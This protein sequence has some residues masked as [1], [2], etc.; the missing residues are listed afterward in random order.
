MLLKTAKATLAAGLIC[1]ISPAVFAAQVIQ[2]KNNKVMIDTQDEPLEVGQEFYLL[3]TDSKKVGL[4]QISVVKNGK[5]IGIVTKGKSGG[6]ETLEL[7]AGSKAS[8]KISEDVEDADSGNSSTKTYRYGSK[9][10]SL[11]LNLITNSMTAKESDGASPTPHIEDVSMTGSSFGLTGVLDSPVNSWFTFRG[12]VGYEPFKASGT[13]NY[14]GCDSATSTNCT[15]EMTYLSV[16]AY[17]RFDFYKSNALLAWGAIGGTT[18]LPIS[19]SS[20]ALKTDDIKITATYGLAI[21]VDYF[22]THKMF[23]PFSIEQQTFMPSDTVKASVMMIRAGV[24]MAY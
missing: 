21:G 13:A 2:V 5:A 24:G 22:M 12:T 16:G 1:L 18:K 8:S 11:V 14:T 9:K 6:D 4:V 10:L 15:A 23:I 20:T 7:K 19:K 17:G 3:N